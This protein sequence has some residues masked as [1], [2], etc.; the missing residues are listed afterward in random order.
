VACR[1]LLGLIARGFHAR[2]LG[3]CLFQAGG[4]FDVEGFLGGVDLLEQAAEDFAGANLN[5]DA[6]AGGYEGVHAIYPANRAGDLADECVAGGFSGGDQAAGDVGG[7]RD[8]GIGKGKGSED[9]GDFLLRGLHECAVEGRADGEHYGAAGAFG[10]GDGRGSFDSSEGTG[11]DGLAGGVEVGRGDGEAGFGFGFAT[12]FGHLGGVQGEDGGHGALTGGN[13]QLHGPA[14]GFD[15]ADSIGKTEGSGGDV[16]RPLAERMAGG[17]GGLNAVRG[18]DAPGGDAD[19]ED[20]R[21]GVLREAEVFFR[22]FKDEFGER[23][24]EGFIGFSK[25]LGGEGKLLGERA[26]HANGLRTLPRKEEGNLGGHSIE[27]LPSWSED[28]F[29]ERIQFQRF[30][31]SG[32]SRIWLPLPSKRTVRPCE[33]M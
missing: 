11:D 32:S 21:L 20:G 30:L 12:G 16:C 29:S 17:K 27:I 26:A 4:V 13:G 6:S 5:E 1:G 24:T 14:T 3:Q 7:Y 9:A 2:K 22:A 8:A 31:S 23:E 18:E 15:R 33:R 19:G 28:P 10:F 25:G